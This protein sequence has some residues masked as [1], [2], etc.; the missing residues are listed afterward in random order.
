MSHAEQGYECRFN[1]PPLEKPLE[2]T[3]GVQC[4]PRY[5]NMNECGWSETYVNFS[6]DHEQKKNNIPRST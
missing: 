3:L 4:I 1:T 5:G 2:G 6:N